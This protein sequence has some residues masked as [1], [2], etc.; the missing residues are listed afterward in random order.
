MPNPCPKE[1]KFHQIASFIDPGSHVFDMG[2]GE[3][4]LAPVLTEKGCRVDGVDINI[5]RVTAFRSHYNNLYEGN[6]ESF[7]FDRH[8]R[9]YDVVVLSDVL[10]RLQ[11]P[12]K[13]LEK[14]GAFLKNAA[15]S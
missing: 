5:R 15:R 6:I 10:E 7:A 4:Q 1:N 3:G 11:D 2:C 14:C 13:V 9:Q 8:A 12:G